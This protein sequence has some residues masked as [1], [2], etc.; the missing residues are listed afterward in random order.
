LGVFQQPVK[1]AGAAGAVGL[2]AARTPLY[3]ALATT[4]TLEPSYYTQV[5]N[6]F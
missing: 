6:L 1:A 3:A 2:V 4:V 5:I